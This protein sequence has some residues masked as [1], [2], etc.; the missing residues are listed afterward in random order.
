[1][2]VVYSYFCK[3]GGK[4]ICMEVVCIFFKKRAFV[5]TDKLLID[6]SCLFAGWDGGKKGKTSL[7][8]YT[9]EV[10]TMA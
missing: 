2:C 5:R 8:L 7:S 3:N 9:F 1:M 4:Y 10:S 6:S